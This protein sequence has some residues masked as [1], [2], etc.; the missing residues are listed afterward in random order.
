MGTPTETENE[1]RQPDSACP[2]E[3][4]RT[5]ANPGCCQDPRID[6]Q[7]SC[8][9]RSPMRICFVSNGVYSA[10]KDTPV[11]RIGGAEVQQSI[12]G[13]CM[14]ANNHHV[15][16]AT[17]VLDGNR[18]HE[19]I[20]G[21]HVYKNY[22][23][24]DGV[25]ILRF[26]HP[27]MSRLWDSLK[28]ADAD[29]YYQRCADKS[30]GVCA[31]FCKRY[32]RKFIFSGAHDSD[33]YPRNELRLRERFLY[34]WGLRNADLI[35]VQSEQQQQLLHQNFGLHGHL[36]PNVYPSRKLASCQGY[37][38]WVGNM[39]EFKRPLLCLEV[40][41]RFPHRQF[42]MIGGTGSGGADLFKQVGEQKPANVQVLGYQPLAETERYFDGASLLLNTS[43]VEGFPNTYLQAWSRGIPVVGTFDPNNLIAENDLGRAVSEVSDIGRW[44]DDLCDAGI[45]YRSRI[46]HHFDAHFTPQQYVDRLLHLLGEQNLEQHRAERRDA[47]DR[48]DLRNMPEC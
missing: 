8:G 3:S 19:V 21:M 36:M 7:S 43:S 40:A 44:F 2:Q 31:Y 37:V 41:R 23:P 9:L 14:H 45:K 16:F 18:E 10:L 13:R 22:A 11:P 39:R 35:L 1:V 27:R 30:T 15:S 6:E 24:E 4:A 17:N 25:P 28:Q 5:A 48:I 20:D 12:I 34:R 38:L 33:F 29:V 47:R 26:F 32:G 42:I 46:Q